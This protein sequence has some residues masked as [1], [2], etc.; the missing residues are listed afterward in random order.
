MLPKLRDDEQGFTLI[1]LLVVI[2]I[3]GILAAIALPTF[4]GQQTKGQDAA[5]KSDA[6]NAVTQVESCFADT[7]D[8]GQCPGPARA[9]PH[10]DLDVGAGPVVVTSG[11]ATSYNVTATSDSSGRRSPSPR[12]SAAAVDAYVAPPPARVAAGAAAAGETGPPPALASPRHGPGHRPRRRRRPAHRLVPQR[13]GLSPA[14]RRV[15]RAAALALPEL[16]H[17]AAG[18]RQHPRRLVAGAARRAAT[19]A[20]RRSPRATRSSRR[21]PARSTPRSWPAR[22]TR[23]A[24]SSGLL[25]VTVLV[26]ITLIDLDHRIIPN[27]ITGP[28]AV[29][30]L[31]V[32]AAL[33]PD[34]LP[35]AAHRRPSPAAGSSSSPRCSTRA[36]WAWATSSSPACWGSTSVA[37][38]RRPSSSP[39]SPA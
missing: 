7:Q 20:A 21:R 27:R 17:T 24:S 36:A 34:F 37:P 14:A 2:L 16:R 13:G 8:Y 33:D 18:A 5:A 30:A 15:A 11:A 35:E 23:S 1:E 12:R 22:T 39:S 29:A 38:W 10:G 3:I 31:V 32:I 4:L 28:A 25:L 6:R 9:G 26:P 19:S